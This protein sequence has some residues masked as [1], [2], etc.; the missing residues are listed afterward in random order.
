[1]NRR[2]L[3]VLG[4]ATL[5]G[6]VP[7]WLLHRGHA[8]F[9]PEN[10]PEGAWARVVLSVGEGRPRDVFPFLETRAQWAAYTIRDFRAASARRVAAAYP[11]PE[12]SRLLAE[13]ARVAAAP[14]GSDVFAI[15]AEERGMLARLRRDLSGL[16]APPEIVGERATVETARG[17][18]YGFRRRENGIWGLTTFTA[19]LVAEA[20]KAARDADVVSRAAD[21]Y[22]RAAGETR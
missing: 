21:D 2:G 18:R 11:E 1:M 17:T 12:R 3:V 6:A 19:E 5:A 13:H 9:P 8:R 22:E 20:E 4:V 15:L 10:T 14:D 16:R 7:A